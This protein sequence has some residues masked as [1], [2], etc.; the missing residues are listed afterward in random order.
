MLARKPLSLTACLLVA[1]AGGSPADDARPD[2]ERI[3]ALL[4]DLG[5]RRYATREAA[6]KALEAIGEPAW[7]PLR[8]LA[9]TSADLETRRRATRLVEVIRRWLFVEVRRF[10]APQ[11]GYWVN[12][13][14]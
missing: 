3:P 10:E 11:A 13:V 9:T 4:R 2:E 8:K 14:A 12:R 5:D 1:T 7:Y 6:T